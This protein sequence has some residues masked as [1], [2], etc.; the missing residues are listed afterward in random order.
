MG[1]DAF[2]VFGTLVA[3]QTPT[4]TTRRVEQTSTSVTRSGAWYTSSSSVHSGGS[5]AWAKSAGAQMNLTFTG[6]GIKLIGPK[7]PTFGRLSVYIDGAYVGT[8]SQ[9][10]SKALYRQVLYSKTGLSPASHRISVRWAGT[11]VAAS[12]GALVGVDAFDV[13]SAQ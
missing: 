5:Y 13:V 7:Y 2:D 9:Y 6:T 12:H 8:C 4:A 11:K 10:S 3:P 1:I